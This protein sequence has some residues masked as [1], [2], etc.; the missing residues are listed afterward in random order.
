M[1]VN[2][3]SLNLITYIEFTGKNPHITTL[4]DAPALLLLETGGA[5]ALTTN[6]LKLLFNSVIIL[7]LLPKEKMKLS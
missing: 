1:V 2:F 3:T 5:V 6:K 7:T 4:K